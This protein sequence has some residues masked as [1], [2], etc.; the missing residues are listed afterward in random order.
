MKH[1]ALLLL[2]LLC[3]SANAASPKLAAAP[4]AP[5]ETPAVDTMQQAGEAGTTIVGERDSDVGLYL[6]PW[7]EEH[8]DNIDP[9]PS[10]LDEPPQPVDARGFARQVRDASTITAYRREQR[11]PNR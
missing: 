3:C 8:P 11:L 6:T 4:A 5:A 10:L 9:P 2:A 7:K 1:C